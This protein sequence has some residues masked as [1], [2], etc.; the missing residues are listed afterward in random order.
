[1]IREAGGDRSQRMRLWGHQAKQRVRAGRPAARSHRCPR[2]DQRGDISDQEV[3]G[4]RR[5]IHRQDGGGSDSTAAVSDSGANKRREGKNVVVSRHDQIFS[6]LCLFALSLLCCSWIALIFVGCLLDDLLSLVSCPTISGDTEDPAACL[7]PGYSGHGKSLH[8][9]PLYLRFLESRRCSGPFPQGPGLFV[10][11]GARRIS[12]GS[13]ARTARK[14]RAIE[15]LFPVTGE[16]KQ[17][18]SSALSRN[19]RRVEQSVSC[20]S[21]TGWAPPPPPPPPSTFVCLATGGSSAQPSP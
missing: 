20:V 1:M 2:R 8:A 3:R 18:W 21:Q 16:D 11:G 10:P 9:P 7:H 5:P 6:T 17:S 12:R 19:W 13:S 4:G 15:G 14:R